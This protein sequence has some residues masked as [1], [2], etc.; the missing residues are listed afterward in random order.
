MKIVS[1]AFL[2]PKKDLR[3]DGL[4]GVRD[5]YVQKIQPRFSNCSPI[6][7]VIVKNNNSGFHCEIDFIEYDKRDRIFINENKN[8]FDYKKRIFENTDK[9]TAAMII[10]TGIGA[11]IG[12]FCGDGNAAARLLAS[13]CDTLITH[14]NVV[15]ASDINEMT[16]NTLYIEGSILTKLFMGKIGLQKTRTNRLLMIMDKVKDEYFNNEVINAV[17]SARVTLGVECDVLEIANPIESRSVYSES[18]RAV[19]IV[20]KFENLV[21]LIKSIRNE[22]DAIGLTT[23]IKVSK[24]M[25][26]VYFTGGDGMVNPWGGLEAMITHSLAEI[27][28]LN[29]AHSPLSGDMGELP[30]DDFGIV[31]PRKAPETASVTFLHCI[32]KGLQ[33]APRITEYGKGIN[34]DDISCLVTTDGCIG[35][36]LLAC[37][38]N[39]I[40]V[41]AVKNKNKMKNDLKTLPFK[42]G[43]LFFA[44]NY[45]EAAGIMT[46]LK[47]GVSTQSV[48]RPIAKTKLIKK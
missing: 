12:G 29:C 19:G 4:K 20:N 33:K 41:I 22:Y 42:N 13:A 39:D 14:P 3:L 34:L 46:A 21:N 16:E 15:N 31:D 43:K 17:S 11:E 38:E 26:K 18:G 24:E 28:D 7:F 25:R 23:V 2:I 40:P 9:F 44:N 35:L 1:K 32:L 5:Y 47:A 36:P 27:F 48:Q 30:V 10:P 45:L 37:L 6:R 8:I